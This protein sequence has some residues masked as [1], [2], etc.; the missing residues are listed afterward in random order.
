[1]IT[2]IRMEV[3]QHFTPYNLNKISAATPS[4][5]RCLWQ[6]RVLQQYLNAQMESIASLDV[7]FG[8]ITLSNPAPAGTTVMN[9]VASN[10]ESVMI[11]LQTAGY[12]AD[13]PSNTMWSVRALT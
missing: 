11:D 6:V 8:L 13:K 10:G 9:I 3:L 12:P 4:G 5:A 1:M 7:D 2:C